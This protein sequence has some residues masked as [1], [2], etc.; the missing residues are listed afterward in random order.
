MA[1]DFRRCTQQTTETGNGV[2]TSWWR[3]SCFGLYWPFFYCVTKSM[4]IIVSLRIW[5][6][7]AHRVIAETRTTDGQMDDGFQF[8]FHELG[9]QYRAELRM[10]GCTSYTF[11]LTCVAGLPWHPN[12]PRRRWRRT[13]HTKLTHYTSTFYGIDN[14]LGVCTSDTR[15][16]QTGT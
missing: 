8:Q 1:L 16:I 3:R 6:K 9:W 12:S 4:Q 5:K 2:P 13:Y 11:W 7:S 15:N 14:A 10:W